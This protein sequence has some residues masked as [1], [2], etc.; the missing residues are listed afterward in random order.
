MKLVVGL[1]NPG[2]KYENTRHNVGFEVIGEL[3]RRYDVGRPKAKFDG[4]FAEA[5]I[6]NEKT[7]LL[8]PLTFMNLSGRC[9]QPIVDFYKIS[10]DDVLILC[11]DLNLPLGRLRIK[12]SGSAGGQNGLKDI[13]QR[14]GSRDVPRLRIGIGSAPPKWDVSDYVLGKFEPDDRITIDKGI[15]L[16][17]DAVE[18]WVS[19]GVQKAMNKYNAD[20]NAPKK[21][22]KSAPKKPAENQDGTAAQQHD[23]ENQEQQSNAD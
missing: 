2:R 20:P 15:K 8:C 18:L 16:A 23:L 1:G 3:A 4:E 17:A 5:R 10:I 21:A 11:D 19:Q 22:K 6:G 13:I 14:L 12:P 7:I 9:V